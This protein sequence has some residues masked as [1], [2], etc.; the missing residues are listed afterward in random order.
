MYFNLNNKVKI[1]IV[2][3][4]LR[5][6][7]FLAAE[8]NFLSLSDPENDDDLDVLIEFSEGLEVSKDAVIHKAPIGYD[9]KGVFWFDPNNKIAR[10]DFSNFDTALT[11]LTVSNDFNTH[12][13]YILILYLI[14]FKSIRNEGVFCHASAVKYRSK[15]IIFPAWRHVGKTNLMLELLKDGAELISDDGIIYYKNGQI[16][17]FS[18]R[19]HLLYFNFLSNPD[20]LE[21]ADDHTSKLIDFVDQARSGH[22]EL[23]DRTI[24]EVQKLIRVRLPNSLITK[25]EFKPAMN[26]CN[27]IVHLNKKVSDTDLPTELV[28]IDLETL[29]VKT[30]E[31]CLFELDHFVEAYKISSL[32][33]GKISNIMDNNSNKIRDITLEAF[34]HADAHMELSFSN[35]LN[36]TEAKDL[37]DTYLNEA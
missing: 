32:I 37:L 31:S 11:K 3:A 23:S 33:E 2:E 24:E 10:I 22:Y 6:Q 17:T 15:T 4:P 7:E 5:F 14:S 25:K 13:L 8:L 21:G 12:F 35:F 28:E 18:K 9:H 16:I 20:L 26:K 36:S 29:S 34:S 27:L 1:R 30:T 19:L